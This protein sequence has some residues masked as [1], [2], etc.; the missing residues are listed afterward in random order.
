MPE[1][2]AEWRMVPTHP[3]YEASSDG[4]L[5][6]RTRGRGTWPG[7]LLKMPPDTGGYP[8]VN[9]DGSP[10]RVHVLVAETFLGPIP[11][12][13]EVHHVSTNR[14]DA[15]VANLK[16]EPSHLAHMEHH[17]RKSSGRRRHGEANP[18]IGCGCGCGQRFPK[19]DPGG[20]PRIYVTGHNYACDPI[21]GN[22]APLRIERG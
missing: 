20:R 10:W 19:F 9:I 7:R 4:R 18:L 21:T 16:V 13:A 12:G 14:A 1:D 8:T 11:D 3:D 6:R 22:Y 17:R 5:R 2:T 15:S